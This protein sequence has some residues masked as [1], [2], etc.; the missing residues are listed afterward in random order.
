VWG[1]ILITNGS[2]YRGENFEGIA[3]YVSNYPD[4]Y[5]ALPRSIE[6]KHIM[7][8]QY[9]FQNRNSAIDLHLVKTPSK[10]GYNL[11]RT[12]DSRNVSMDESEIQK[13]F[14]AQNVRIQAVD[15]IKDTSLEKDLRKILATDIGQFTKNPS[16]CKNGSFVSYYPEI[17][18]VTS[19]GYCNTE[20]LL[21]GGKQE[22]ID[23]CILDANLDFVTQNSDCVAAFVPGKNASF[24]NG[25]FTGFY[26]MSDAHCTYCYAERNH[27]EPYP[28]RFVKIEPLRLYNDLRN[29]NINN[30]LP[31]EEREERRVA[32]TVA[33]IDA[34]A[35]GALRLGKRTDVGA[36]YNR[37]QLITTLETCCKTKTK[38]VLTTKFLEYDP[39][40]V[41]LLKK[42]KTS[43]MFSIT[44]FYIPERI[45]EFELGPVLHGCDTLWRIEQAK[46]YAD[47]GV[48][49]GLFIATDT[50]YK[51]SA[52]FY[53]RLDDYVSH[54]LK[55]QV[56]DAKITKKKQ[57]VAEVITGRTWDELKGPLKTVS[58]GALFGKETFRQIGG[59]SFHG[60]KLK[61][62]VV[63]PELE[64][65]IGANHGEKRMCNSN[66]N[67]T[68]CG[69]CGLYNGFV[70]DTKEKKIVKKNKYFV[71]PKKDLNV[72][73]G[74]D[75]GD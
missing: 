69:T 10:D 65:I 12:I 6:G 25:V 15:D 34:V 50:V 30:H 32:A 53:N 14:D 47:A 71:R 57:D 59:Y 35:V 13:I 24:S 49:T 16:T 31:E 39:Y 18:P 11:K 54:K 17:T 38:P 66:E 48:N 45:D 61:P 42:S 72:K 2:I 20:Y 3:L 56:L 44:D 74:F 26:V 52:A 9:G 5:S 36:I 23:G 27:L 22:F 33:A 68:W 70:K 29:W 40:L 41:E 1:F 51:K 37:G 28:K 58:S 63:D 46:R 43:L 73:L 19:I 4:V 75:F 64:R 8:V 60:G 62:D 67:N 7:H 55:V 21:Q